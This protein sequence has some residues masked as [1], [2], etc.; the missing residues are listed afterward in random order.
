MQDSGGHS[1]AEAAQAIK[2]STELMLEILN[3]I[4]DNKVEII[5]LTGD[6][7]GGAASHYLIEEL[8]KLGVMPDKPSSK[9]LACDLHNF[10]KPLEVACVDTWGGQGIGSKSPFQMVWLFV[11]MMKMLRGEVGRDGLDTMWGK[12]ILKMRS[13]PT[14][15]DLASNNFP[16]AYDMFVTKL[17]ELED[18]DLDAALEISSAAPVN[19]QDPVFSRWGTVLAA[20]S[21][22]VKHWSTI[23]FFALTIKDDRKSGCHIWQIACA[24][25]SLMNNRDEEEPTNDGLSRSLD[26]FIGS[27]QTDDDAPPTMKLK[28][29]QTP[30]FLAVLQFLDGF[31]KA[32]FDG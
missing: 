14:W 31:N 16:Q 11:R 8:I 26:D 29:G 30:I 1:A 27:F 7:G 20:I 18:T 15:M 10:V 13:D 2:L 17:N 22:F 19:I 9:M 3:E 5:G 21:V 6:S 4:I 23:Y 12:T 28:A 24:L 25:L 32:Y